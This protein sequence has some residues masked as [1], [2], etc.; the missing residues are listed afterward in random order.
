MTIYIIEHLE[1]RMWKWCVIEYKHISKIVGKENLWI[2]NVRKGSTVLEKCGKV[3]KQSVAELALKKCCVLDPEAA[4]TLVPEEIGN[5]DYFIFGGILGDY[6]PKKRTK[7][8]LTTRIKNAEAR[9]IGKA[10]M[11]TD[12]AVT[13]VK[14]I[15]DGKSLEELRFKDKLEIPLGK[16]ESTILPYRYLLVNGKPLMSNELVT[17]LK[18]KKGF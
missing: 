6:P 4:Q 8:E 18:R 2:T 17:Y 11:S 7:K 15:A 14:E 3:I 16:N 13:V 10:Q 1:Q 9:N 12:N 5:F